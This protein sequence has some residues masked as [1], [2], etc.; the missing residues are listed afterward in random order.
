MS[1][2]QRQGLSQRDEELRVPTS[3]T[4]PRPGH[5]RAVLRMSFASGLPHGRGGGRVRA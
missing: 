2:R 3:G 1:V 5:E 4:S